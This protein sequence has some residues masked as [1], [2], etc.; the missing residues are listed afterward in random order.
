MNLL[1]EFL[2]QHPENP[3]FLGPTNPMYRKSLRVD[4]IPNIFGFAW[5]SILGM[6]VQNPNAL[7]YGGI[8]PVF[9]GK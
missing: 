9:V 4:Y 1:A 7:E 3:W 6:M 2:N 5:P 8:Y